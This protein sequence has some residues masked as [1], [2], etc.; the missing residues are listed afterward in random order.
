MSPASPVRMVTAMVG[1]IPAIGRGGRNSRGG[2]PPGELDQHFDDAR[3]KPAGPEE[4]SR[5]LVRVRGVEADLA[6][7]DLTEP[8][9]RQRHHLPGDA[10]VAVLLLDPQVVDEAEL[11][12]A[13]DRDLALD[14]ADEE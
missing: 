1:S 13:I 8:L 3:P 6:H 7:A 12:E 5:R 9:D 11:G 14:G 10:L 2:A 4:V